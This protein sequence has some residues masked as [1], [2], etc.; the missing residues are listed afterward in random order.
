VSNFGLTIREWEMNPHDQDVE[1]ALDRVEA[2]LWGERYAAAHEAI[3]KLD[4]DALRGATLARAAVLRARCDALHGVAIDLVIMEARRALERV[5]LDDERALLR[6]EI[7]YGLVQKRCEPLARREAEAI[8]KLAPASSLGPAVHAWIDLRNDR[9]PEALAAYERAEQLADGFRGTMG[10]ARVAY[11]LGDLDRCEEA[12]AR[13]SDRKDVASRRLRQLADVARVR[14]RW[15]RVLSLLDRIAEATPGGDYARFDAIERAVTLFKLDRREEGLALYKTIW[16]EKEDDGAGRFARAV[17]THVERAREETPSARGP[18]SRATETRPGRRRAMLPEFPTVTQK[19]NYC[20]PATLEL[21]LR[22]LS[23]D[24]Q[25]T[26]DAIAAQIKRENG[27]AV[28]AMRRYLEGCGL[29]VR[30]FEATPAKLYACIAAGLPVIV[31]EEYSTTNHVA[32]VIGVDEELGVLHVQD[33]MTHVTNTRLVAT[34]GEL[35]LHF[36]NAALVAFRADDEAAK[37]ALD[38]AEVLD[39]PHIALVDECG[40]D[41]VA[42]QPEEVLRRCARAIELCEDY[43]LAWSRQAWALFGHLRRYRTKNNEKRFLSMLR[44]VRVK[45]GTHEWPHQLHG[46]WLM[47]EGRHEE[48][49]I[50]FEEALRLDPGDSN[51]AQYIAECH[52]QLGRDDDAVAA[53]RRALAIDPAHVRATENYAALALDGGELAMASHLSDCACVMAPGNPFNW[54]TASRVAHQRGD[55]AQALA[56]ARKA[57]EV[58]PDYADAQLRL[59]SLLRVAPVEALPPGAD[60]REEA[61]AI[62]AKLVERWPQWFEP[63][64]RF[65]SVLRELDRPDE[66]IALLEHGIQIAQDEPAPLA[67]ELADILIEQGR[68]AEALAHL[69]RLARERPTVPMRSEYF[70]YLERLGV[71]PDG[72][73]ATK[74]FLDEHPDSPYALA[75]HAAWLI[76]GSEEDEQTAETQLRSA[77][78]GAPTYHWA[79]RRLMFAL[80]RTRLDEAIA[81]ADASPEPDAWTVFD[82]VKLRLDAGQDALPTLERALTLGGGDGW[83]AQELANR[84]LIAGE[85]ALDLAKVRAALDAED[86]PALWRRRARLAFALAEADDEAARAL[87]ATLPAEDVPTRSLLVHAADCS[88]ALRPLLEERLAAIVADRKRGH[89]ERAWACAVLAGSRAA[90]AERAGEGTAT[91]ETWLAAQRAL[92]PLERAMTTLSPSRQH[93]LL[94]MTRAALA[95]LPIES[96]RVAQQAAFLASG[97]GDHARAIALLRAARERWARD[98]SLTIA[99]AAE[100]LLTDPAGWDEARALARKALS[101]DH[102]WAHTYEIAALAELAAGDRAHGERLVHGATRRYAAMGYRQSELPL[103]RAG[104]AVVARDG[105]ALEAA[106]TQRGNHGNPEAAL[107]EALAKR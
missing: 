90:M 16:R 65:A 24:A 52:Q 5:E 41:A 77:V 83:Y 26:Q 51:N 93:A 81:L 64:V 63:R 73:E 58:D 42:G 46:H 86:A 85:G 101:Q 59:A 84:V 44:Q 75:T 87:V 37:G 98:G 57:T 76:G 68:P 21:V 106:R 15:E 48:S 10:V 88:E 67:R 97:Q 23:V 70:D 89:D 45:Y 12:L 55:E 82:E 56:H 60:G 49:L 69:A 95:A 32:V 39:A 107:W 17:L 22:A 18:N 40:D 92:D 78:E 20:G 19:R 4:L 50:E 99:L 29:T 79:R 33:P 2:D 61:R 35:G 43:P 1:Q 30:R 102:A 53:F 34:Q 72:R 103:L 38:A 96:A 80:G 31:E 74:A 71:E 47:D 13:V 6:A 27:T 104:L 3:A 66:A 28:I 25:A 100:L 14:G 7:A 94:A 9:R 54:A 8:E 105:A 91:Y 11:V 62:Y 36:R